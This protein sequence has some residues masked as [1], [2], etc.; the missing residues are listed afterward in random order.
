VIIDEL[1]SRELEGSVERSARIAWV[2]GEFLLKIV[3]PAEFSCRPEDASP[4]VAAAL[5]PAMHLH[6]DLEIDGL[7]S[8]RLLRRSDLVQSA[9]QAW[10]PSLRRCKVTVAGELPP[11]ARSDGVG[12]FF[13]RGVDSTF[14]AASERVEPGPLTCLIFCE[15]LEPIHDEPVR[16][17]ELRLAREAARLLQLPL[18]VASTNLRDLTE[19][20]IDWGDMHGAGLAFI[21]L[22]LAGGTRHVVVPSTNGFAAIGPNGSSP[23]LDPLFSTETVEIEHDSIAHGR[24]G[25]VA[26]LAR[27]RPDL[28][29]YLKVCYSENRPDNCGRCGKCIFTMA[30]LHAA[31]ALELATGFPPEIDAETIRRR[32]FPTLD[33]RINCVELYRALGTSDADQALRSAILHAIRRSARPSLAERVR[34]LV[35]RNGRAD[36][37]WSS[38]WEAFHRH[39]TNMAVSLLRDGRPYP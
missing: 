33:V 19:N 35:R 26:W 36:P 30:C 18:V 39:G 31:G 28:L 10:D 14:S 16:A 5:L 23:L 21:G 22:S 9:Y 4:L 20:L 2:G 25:K 7:V 34:S 27:E 37:A 3:V 29:P 13:S 11:G 6:E 17:E 1:R 8:A 12:C 32:R 38:S 24:V 15:T